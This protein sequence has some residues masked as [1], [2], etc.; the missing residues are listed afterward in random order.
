LE[1][2]WGS[3]LKKTSGR[4]K[5]E[6]FVPSLSNERKSRNMKNHTEPQ[7][8]KVPDGPPP[9]TM[10][11]GKKGWEKEKSGKKNLGDIPERRRTGGVR[12]KLRSKKE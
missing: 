5:E 10:Q 11:T 4:E 2:C 3:G 7:K 6:R 8:G 12:K 9:G 1:N